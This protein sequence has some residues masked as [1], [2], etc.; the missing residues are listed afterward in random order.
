MKFKQNKKT[1]N[2]LRKL[3]RFQKFEIYNDLY[4][5]SIS[6]LYFL[7]LFFLVCHLFYVLIYLEVLI[8]FNVAFTI[9]LI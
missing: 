7:I 1:N 4:N 5:F 6:L 9:N 2:Y 8:P 3:K